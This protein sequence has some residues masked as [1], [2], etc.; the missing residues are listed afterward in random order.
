MKICVISPGVVHAVPRTIAIA[1]QFD[2]VHFIDMTG[3]ADHK[4]LESHGIVYHGPE[5][6]GNSLIKSRQ[7]RDLIQ[8]IDPEAIVCHY[9]SGDH[10]FSVI[11]NGRCPVA[12]IAMGHD[13]LYDEG[14][15]VVSAFTRFLTRM[16]LR[17]A[18]YIS[19]KS[20]ILAQRLESYGVR[21]PIDVNYWGADLNR[22]HPA[23][24]LESRRKLGL[25]EGRPIILSPRAIEPRLNIHL[26][27]EAFHEVLTRYQDALLV[28]LGRSSPDYKNQIEQTIKRLGL[29]KHVRI[30]GEVSQDTLPLYYQ[31]SDV[32]V[33]MASSEGFPNSLLEVMA[34]KVPVVVGKI[35]HIEELL[36]N[37]KNTWVCDIES[38]AIAATILDVLNDESKRRRISDAA[39][40]TVTE[41]ADIKKSGMTF[42][43]NLKQ[44][45]ANYNLSLGANII[46][47]RLLYGIYRIQRKIMTGLK[48]NYV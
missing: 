31:A 35:V 3:K 2:E 47:F 25:D 7:L 12:A 44:A 21:C 1:C 18:H 33:S 20:R 6:A 30:L 36:E 38:N 26:I 27:I 46:L 14:D 11:A 34:C 5:S 22:Y 16:A 17:R 41:H 8:K 28:I 45:S 43:D 37:G 13:V 9:A 32:M 29:T 23:N 15:S 19:A 10:F 4:T 39:Y 40:M 24:Q 48:A 42:S